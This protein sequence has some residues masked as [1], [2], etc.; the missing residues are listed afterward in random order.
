M[1]VGRGRSEYA[2]R[3]LVAG[4]ANGVQGRVGVGRRVAAYAL[5]LLALMTAALFAAPQ[6][7]RADEGVS[8]NALSDHT[9]TGVSPR[10]TTI[11]LFDYWLT[12]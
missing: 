9:V 3:A 5:V 7:V 8:T 11:N 1:D 4:G 2:P 6:A 12:G 10:G